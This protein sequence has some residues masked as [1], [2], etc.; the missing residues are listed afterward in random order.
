[1]LHITGFVTVCEAFLR[2]EPH[3]DFFR[4]LFSGRA[5]TAMNSSEVTLMGGF[6]LQRK[7]STGG[8]YPAYIPCGSNRGRVMGTEE[9]SARL[10]E[11]VARQAEEFSTLENFHVGTYLF[12]FSSCWFLP[13]AYF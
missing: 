11:H 5:L 9:V 4:W 10:H 8:S 1:M 6:A 7:P 12:Y 2:M 3:A 13:S